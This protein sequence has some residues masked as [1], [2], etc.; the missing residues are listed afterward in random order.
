MKYPNPFEIRLR[1]VR[2]ITRRE[3]T[4]SRFPTFRQYNRDDDNEDDDDG[5]DGSF[6][7]SETTKMQLRRGD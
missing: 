1:L 7:S 4:I 3:R 5:D 2:R 6:P